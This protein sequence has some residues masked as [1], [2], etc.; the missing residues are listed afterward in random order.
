VAHAGYLIVFAALLQRY[1]QVPAVRMLA[2]TLPPLLACVPMVL[3][4]RAVREALAQVGL[5]GPGLPRLG[6]EVAAGAATYMVAAPILARSVSRDFLNLVRNALR[7][8][9]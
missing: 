3:A 1:E 7:R 8:S 2:S 9:G 6:A 5:D 4:V